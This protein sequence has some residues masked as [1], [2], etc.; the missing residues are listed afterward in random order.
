LRSIIKTIGRQSHVTPKVLDLARWMAEY[1]CC[2]PEIALKTVLPEAVRREKEG[3]REQ[4]F[5]R[6]L[7][8]PETDPKLSKRQTEILAAARAGKE[9]PLQDF[10]RQTNSTSQTLR[11]LED[12]GLLEIATRI[13]ERDPYARDVVLPTT[14]LALN[15]G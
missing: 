9:L 4:L 5:V 8:P 12:K 11:R 6:A 14:S 3:W 7:P 10:L 1:Y 2:P 13:S 15:D